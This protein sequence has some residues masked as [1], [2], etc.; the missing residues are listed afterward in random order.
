MMMCVCV[1][2]WA[3]RG[4][5]DGEPGSL[6]GHR[7]H[8]DGDGMS[9]TSSPDSCQGDVVT[10]RPHDDEE[11]TSPAAGTEAVDDVIVTSRDLLAGIAV[12]LL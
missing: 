6:L 12:L 4:G 3:I 8:N 7:Q 11:Q 1:K 9:G 2:L 5:G 10:H